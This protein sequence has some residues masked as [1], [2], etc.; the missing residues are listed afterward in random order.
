MAATIEFADL[1]TAYRCNALVGGVLV[2]EIAGYNGTPSGSPAFD[3]STPIIGV[4]DALLDGTD[5]WYSVPGASAD[6]NMGTDDFTIAGFLKVPVGGDSASI[7]NKFLGST[8]YRLKLATGG[9]TGQFSITLNIPTIGAFAI[10]A[11]AHGDTRGAGAFTFMWSV[12][13]SGFSKLYMNG[14]LQADTDNIAAFS[15]ISV[16]NTS[17]DMGLG[18]AAGGAPYSDT[19]LGELYFLKGFVGTVDDALL[20]Y[21]S[22]SFLSLLPAVTTFKPRTMVIF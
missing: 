11:A 12:D 10:N 8:G 3:T 1:T 5:D 13:R 17:T 19:T 2:D 20:L 4:G 22:G 18:R 6:L 21:D 14:V 16:S 15:A 9:A 7:I